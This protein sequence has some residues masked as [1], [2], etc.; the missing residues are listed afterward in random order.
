MLEL[1]QFRH[2]P[3]SE[4]VRWALDIKHVPHSRRSLLPGPHMATVKPLTGRTHTPVLLHDGAALD[5]SARI[6]DWLE[7]RYTAPALM[8]ADPDLRDEAQRIQRWFD[9]EITPRIRRPVLDALL[10]QPGYFASIFADGAPAFKRRAYACVVPFAAPLVRKGNGITGAAAVEDGLR[11]GD[12]ALD[13]VAARGAATGYLCGDT[14]SV[15]DLTA[16]S[17]LAVLIRPVD[18]PMSSPQPVARS[19]RELM[20]RFADHAG[21]AWVRRMYSQHRGARRDFDGPSEGRA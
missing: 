4:K 6:L 9:D 16:A 10:R 18:S 11:A 12:E 19:T 2:S 7:A 3:Y 17:T 20:D 14:F 21:A 15:V 8:P 1:L 5:G 13:F